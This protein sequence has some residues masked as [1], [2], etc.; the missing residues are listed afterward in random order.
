[1]S[2]RAAANTVEPTPLDYIGALKLAVEAGAN[3]DSAYQ[4]MCRILEQAPEPDGKATM[5]TK[6]LIDAIRDLGA[7]VSVA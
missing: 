6:I 2:A 3:V 1:M 7:T 5:P 4:L